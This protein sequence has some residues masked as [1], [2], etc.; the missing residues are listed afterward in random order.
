MIAET[1]LPF[2][3]ELTTE[4]LTPHAGLV[5][6]HEFHLGLGLARVLDALL[7][8]PGSHRGYRPM[9]GLLYETRWLL[10]DEFRTGSAAPQSGGVAFI[11]V[12]RAGSS[13]P[14]P[15]GSASQRWHT[16]CS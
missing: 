3:L 13:R 11:Q 7:P 9:V 4:Q 14:T 16:T 6:A 2:K 12:C 8:P 5:L 10:H 15:R 1:V